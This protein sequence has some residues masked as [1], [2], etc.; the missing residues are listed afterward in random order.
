[1]TARIGEAK[2]RAFLKA[3]AQS[4]NLT[5]SAEQAGMSKSWVVK[6]R[7]SD[8]DFDAACRAA[9]AA[10]IEG[11]GQGVSNRPPREWQQRGRVAL[12]VSRAGKRPP[13]V[14][15]AGGGRRW[16]P[17]A[18]ARLLGRLRQCNNLRLACKEAGMTLS[19][20]EAHWRRWPDFRQRVREARASARLRLEAALEAERE[21]PFD[22]SALPEIEAPPLSIAEL[23]RMV[24]RHR[25]GRAGRR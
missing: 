19:S 11:L 16:T 1:M 12:V 10:S 3:F 25:Q 4:G 20:C 22:L 18:E 14:A 13:Q 24:R 5:L 8:P 17:R 23:I 9:K 2:R 6:A 7:R 15:R 21:R